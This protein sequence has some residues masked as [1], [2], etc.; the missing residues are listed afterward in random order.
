MSCTGRPCEPRLTAA[1]TV[2]CPMVGGVGGCVYGG[3]GGTEPVRVRS[4]EGFN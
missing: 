1:R 2:L 4:P 3:G